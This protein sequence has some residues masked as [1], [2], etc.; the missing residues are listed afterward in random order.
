MVGCRQFADAAIAPEAIN[1]KPR[2]DVD[3]ALLADE[4]R[5]HVMEV[6][7]IP[8]RARGTR[9]VTVRAAEVHAALALRARYPVVCSA[10]DGETFIEAAGV[11][12]ISRKGPLHSSSVVWVFGV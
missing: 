8:A 7:I 3:M 11:T 12:L 1:T 10:L 5:E 2:R 6:Y 9:S 4:I